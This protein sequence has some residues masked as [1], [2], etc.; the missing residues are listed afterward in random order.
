MR[1]KNF[2][3]PKSK[4][5]HKR[6]HPAIPEDSLRL[7][8]AAPPASGK[9]NTIMNMIYYLL[10]FDEILLFAK[11][12]QQDKYQF[13]LNDFAKRVDPEAGYK[14]INTPQE[15]IPIRKA[16]QGNDSQ[17]LVIFDDFACEKSQN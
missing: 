4:T 13:F 14:V 11:N 7:V 6:I 9:T 2:D 5:K 16:F 8:I 10:Y 12:L 17:R 15:V 3:V 1:L